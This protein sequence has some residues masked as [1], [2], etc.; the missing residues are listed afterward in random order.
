[1]PWPD[2]HSGSGYCTIPEG[3]N[4][5]TS[6]SLSGGLHFTTVRR[7][8][9]VLAARFGAGFDV[10]AVTA[11]EGPLATGRD[12]ILRLTGTETRD[13][14]AGAIVV[15]VFAALR[16]VTR[17]AASASSKDAL[18]QKLE[19][20]LRGNDGRPLSRRTAASLCDT[21]ASELWGA[22]AL[23]AVV[24]LGAPYWVAATLAAR[25]KGG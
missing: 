22:A 14:S 4:F 13:I 10:F 6:T 25:S 12:V 17:A 11:R 7:A 18:A 3:P 8:G 16:R 5:A 19:T 20:R 2:A 1:M 21:S 24:A 9:F 23:R 15:L